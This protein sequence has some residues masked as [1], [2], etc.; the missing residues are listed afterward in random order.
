VDSDPTHQ[1]M[2][3]AIWAAT[4]EIMIQ[5]VSPSSSVILSVPLAL[6]ISVALGALLG[7][8]GVYFFGWLYGWVGRRLGGQG[9]NLEV[10]TAVAWIKIPIFPAFGIWLIGY[11]VYMI[12]KRFSG[13]EIVGV[14]VLTGLT[15]AAA[16]IAS[17]WSFVLLCKAIGEVHRFSAWRGLGTMMVGNMV[18]AAPFLILGIVAAIAI[19]NFVG[20]RQSALQQKAAQL[21]GGQ[22]PGSAG[23]TPTVTAGATQY[24]SPKRT[25]VNLAVQTGIVDLKDGTVIQGRIMYEDDQML[26][27]ETPERVVNLDK[28]QIKNVSRNTE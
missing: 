28:S 10:R 13:A 4:A 17:M 25:N 23:S 22:P 20:A 5:L 26:Y 6:V 1:V 7:S 27:V 21:T 15:I 3:I 11:A 12:A 16:A 9:Q 2:P 19:P 14:V 8:L 18:I 24:V